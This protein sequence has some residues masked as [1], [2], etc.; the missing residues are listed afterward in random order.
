MY[1][2]D[3]Y[4]WSEMKDVTNKIEFQQKTEAH[5]NNNS[6]WLKQA[7]KEYDSRLPT[8]SFFF[9]SVVYLCFEAIL[10]LDEDILKYTEA[11]AQPDVSRTS[12]DSTQMA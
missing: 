8:S 3:V 7:F 12:S 9:T 1:V 6:I 10:I 11:L 5:V 2:P 4:G